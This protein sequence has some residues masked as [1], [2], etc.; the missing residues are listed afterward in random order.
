MRAL[1]TLCW[2][3][4]PKNQSIFLIRLQ[5]PSD[6]R[7]LLQMLMAGPLQT[8]DFILASDLKIKAQET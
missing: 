2:D 6:N 3:Q 4:E 7:E 8:A 5:H 1:E